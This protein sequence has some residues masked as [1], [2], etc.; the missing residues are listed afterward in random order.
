MRTLIDS[1]LSNGHLKQNAASDAEMAAFRSGNHA[2]TTTARNRRIRLADLLVR[3]RIHRDRQHDRTATATKKARA[4]G[5]DLSPEWRAFV[6]GMTP[7]Q[8]AKATA[9]IRKPA[10]RN[11]RITTRHDLVLDLARSGW[12]TG[13][14]GGKP[15]AIDP[16]GAFLEASQITTTAISFMATINPS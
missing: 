16:D 4:I 2:A 13:T 11:G 8:A 12:T 9:A 1:F 15:A 6:S 14:I 3:A 7:M 10:R 5:A